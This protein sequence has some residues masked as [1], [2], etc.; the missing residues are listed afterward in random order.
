VKLIEHKPLPQESTFTIEGISVAERRTLY[1]A[2]NGA[3]V[4]WLGI[5]EDG[6]PDSRTIAQQQV[7]RFRVMGGKLRLP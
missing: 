6:H 1:D 4:Y 3:L 7:A 2:C 5:L